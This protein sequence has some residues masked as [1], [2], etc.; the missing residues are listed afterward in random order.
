MSSIDAIS[1]GSAAAT[2]KTDSAE[3]LS[4]F[5]DD[6]DNFLQ[7]LIV[8]L[9]NQ[10]PTSPMET[11]EFTQQI[12]SFT[13][14]EQSINTN[15]K[16]ETL[17]DMQANNQSSYLVAFTGKSVEVDGS[18]ITMKDEGDV[19]FSYEIS[20]EEITTAH[21]TIR[22]AFGKTVFNGVGTTD[23]G[24][25][26]IAWDG[27]D[28]DGNRVD[29]G[30]YQIQVTEEDKEGILENVDTQVSGIVTGVVLDKDTPSLVVNGEEIPLD[31]VRF[32]GEA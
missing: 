6:F 27:L 14:V 8:Q 1:G 15:K 22:D 30:L 11:N 12:V 28:N 13:E 32:V 4:K 18:Q 17:I 25:N 5:A 26:V 19:R 9:T 24:R 21:I 16:L 20:D 31:N 23:A 2:G 3:S 10:D 29:S 7:L